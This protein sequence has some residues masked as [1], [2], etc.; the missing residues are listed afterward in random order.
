MADKFMG[1]TVPPPMQPLVQRVR[2]SYLRGRW[3][4]VLLVV[5]VGATLLMLPSLGVQTD[6][7]AHMVPASTSAPQGRVRS[8]GQDIHVDP[9]FLYNEAGPDHWLATVF[10]PGASDVWP[11]WVHHDL[12]SGRRVL[13]SHGAKV[14]FE[15]EPYVKRIFDQLPCNGT[16]GGARRFFVDAGGHVGF[17]T[18]LARLRGCDVVTVEIQPSCMEMMRVTERAN[19][20]TPPTPI[21][22]HP[23][24]DTDDNLFRVAERAGPGGCDGGFSLFWT[25]TMPLTSLRLDTVFAKSP[26][27]IDLMKLDIEGFEPRAFK[28]AERMIKERRVTA[29]LMEATWWPNVFNPISTAYH[30]FSFAF[31]YGYSI[32]CL[33]P[34]DKFSFRN[35]N[36]W[37]KFGESG[38]TVK[39]VY[40][41]DPNSVLVSICAEYLVCLEPCPFT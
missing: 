28:G 29:I 8:T 18:V 39:P 14:I 2:L 4:Y 41:D 34:E 26:R 13:F 32:R 25:G 10:G 9:E 20:I 24:F 40:P 38:D 31:E 37:I 3:I 15:Q 30:Y 5:A 27:H 16:A 11:M 17:Y 12:I 22:T 21:V 6:Y 19:S 36:V 33:S 23:L 7:V 35:P 1:I